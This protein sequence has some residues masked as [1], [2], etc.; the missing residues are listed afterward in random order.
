MDDVVK[1]WVAFS[2]MDLKTATHLYETMNPRPLEI[3]CYHCQQ[4]AEKILKAYLIYWRIR[5]DRTHDLRLLRGE[6]EKIDDTFLK[7]ADECERL[8][9]YSSQPRYPMEIEIYDSDA[10]KALDDIEIIFNFTKD[11][12][13]GGNISAKRD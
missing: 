12:I 2:E 11:K 7:V 3:I 8:N 1:E 5:P 4:S 6:C 13:T 10:S 9:P